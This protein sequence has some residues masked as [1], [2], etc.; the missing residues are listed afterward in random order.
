[1]SGPFP[2][3]LAQFQEF[4]EGFTMRTFIRRIFRRHPSTSEVLAAL[5]HSQVHLHE[6]VNELVK[7]NKRRELLVVSA[8]HFASVFDDSHLAHDEQGRFSDRQMSALTGLLKAAG[9]GSAADIWLS[10]HIADDDD[11]SPFT[12]PVSA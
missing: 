10:Y 5:V 1:V 2:W 9:Y 12:M 7:L 8:H 4:S 6:Q 11:A 3:A